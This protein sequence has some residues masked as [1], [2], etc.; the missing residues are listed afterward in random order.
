MCIRDRPWEGYNFEDAVLINQRL[1]YDDVFISL[2][3]ERYETEIR[4]TQFGPE[5]ITP[6]PNEKNLLNLLDNNGIIKLGTWVKEG[7][8]LVGKTSPVGKRKLSAYEKLLFDII[9][10]S[11]PTKKDTSLQ[12]PL[13]IKG[14][15]IHIEIIENESSSNLKTKSFTKV[16]KLSLIHI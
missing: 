9:G 10:K 14:R 11:I 5:E 15:V 2:H 7:D 16:N 6:K 4:E 13:G 3:I 8:I 1:V 12:V